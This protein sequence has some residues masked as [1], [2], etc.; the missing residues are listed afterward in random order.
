M[1]VKGDAMKDFINAS[2]TRNWTMQRF[3]G[4]LKSFCRRYG[5]TLNPKD[6]HNSQGRIIRKNSSGKS[7][8]MIYVQTAECGEIQEESYLI[9]NGNDRIAEESEKLSVLN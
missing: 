6:F 8:E 1:L 3:T 4:S 2:N 5:Y 7:V 9:E